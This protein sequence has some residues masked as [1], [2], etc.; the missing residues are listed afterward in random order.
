[1]NPEQWRPITGWTY[2]SWKLR[3]YIKTEPL[4]KFGAHPAVRLTEHD[5]D[6]D[7]SVAKLMLIA[8]GKT[9][10]SNYDAII[11]LVRDGDP[12]NI[13][14]SN[15]TF[16]RPTPPGHR[17]CI[18]AMALSRDIRTALMRFRRRATRGKTLLQ[19]GFPPDP[20]SENSHYVTAQGGEMTDLGARTRQIGTFLVNRENIR[21]FAGGFGNRLFTQKAGS[22]KISQKP[23]IL[24]CDALGLSRGNIR[25]EEYQS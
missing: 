10:A 8:F 19:K 1:M 13:R 16:N 12:T 23:L 4:G 3:K 18:T 21:V 17:S 9:T 22:R 6:K 15:L 20:P 24:G 5:E 2:Y 7:R 14:L 11:P 25:A